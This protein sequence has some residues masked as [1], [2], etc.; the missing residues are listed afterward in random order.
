MRLPVLSGTIERRIL[1]NYRVD[2]EV[3]GRLLPPPF[4]PQLMGAFGIAGICLIRLRKIR[5]RGWMA[6][7]G[8]SSENAAHRIAVEWEDAG[9]T[10]RGVYVPRRDSSSWFNTLVGGRLFPGV[11]HLSRFEVR[12]SGDDYHI[13]ISHRDGMRVSVEGR[14]ADQLPADSIFSSL[15]EASRFLADGS[16]GYSATGR[17]GVYDGLELRTFEWRIEPLAVDHV[18]SS[19]FEDRRLFPTGSATFDSAFLMRDIEH[20]WHGKES[21]CC[22]ETAG[23]DRM[24]PQTARIEPAVQIQSSDA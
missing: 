13:R 23:I 12:E 10:R 9:T 18:A 21:L 3:L 4:R 5:P 1:V 8:F 2:P 6:T 19:L 16:L 7:V 17:S 14:T 24:H 20:E 22:A 11:H 15:S